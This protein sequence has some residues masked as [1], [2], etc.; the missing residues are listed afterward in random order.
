MRKATQKRNNKE[1]CGKCRIIVRL[2][3][4]VCS[5]CINFNAY[6]GYNFKN[7]FSGYIGYNVK[8]SFS[9]NLIDTFNRIAEL[10]LKL[11]GNF[12][13]KFTH[14]LEGD[15]PATQAQVSR[16]GLTTEPAPI[17]SCGSWLSPCVRS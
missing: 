8:N 12:K 3:C 6:I 7:N 17:C 13:S 10:K 15:R 11:I 4:F 14:N 5:M 16:S 1:N 2:N 9:G